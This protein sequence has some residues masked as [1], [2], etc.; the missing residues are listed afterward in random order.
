MS[1]GL[2]ILTKEEIKQLPRWALV[3]FAARCSRRVLP[4]FKHSWQQDPW[5]FASLIEKAVLMIENAAKT[6]TPHE[7]LATEL[8]SAESEAIEA[9]HDN[10]GINAA[11][12]VLEAT[13]YADCTSCEKRDH[14]NAALEC[15][16]AATKAANIFNV[17]IRSHIRNDFEKILDVV[18]ANKLTDETPVAPE[19]F[20]LMWPNGKPFGWPQLE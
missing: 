13:F 17:C 1:E 2:S 15:C 19:I 6:G 10:N 3:A 11:A 7:S 9:S 14:V 20:G 8:D 12:Y 4:L 5:A 18:K 16:T